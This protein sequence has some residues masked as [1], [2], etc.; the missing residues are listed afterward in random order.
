MNKCGN[1]YNRLII[2]VL[3]VKNKNSGLVFLR[4]GVYIFY[5]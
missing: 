4:N 2:D 1:Y 3:I 5:D